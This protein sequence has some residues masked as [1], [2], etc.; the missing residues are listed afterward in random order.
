LASR[1]AERAKSRT[2]RGL[3]TVTCRPRWRAWPRPRA[4]RRRSP[5]APRAPRRPTARRSLRAVP[6]A[7]FLDEFRRARTDLEATYDQIES[8]VC[9]LR[10][11]PHSAG[12]P[13]RA[14]S[15]VGDV[16]TALTTRRSRGTLKLTAGH[17]S[18]MQM[19]L[20]VAATLSERFALRT[21]A[22][23]SRHRPRYRPSRPGEPRL[24]RRH[25]RLTRAA[26]VVGR[27]LRDTMGG[28]GNTPLLWSGSVRSGSGLGRPAE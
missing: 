25:E 10:N 12:V 5:R 11:V 3:T 20:T 1:P 22:R 16:A 6:P 7:R 26:F 8:A 14:S 19:S 15:R 24:T 2:W 13:G 27:W 9:V 23:P 21:M 4:R 18:L 17:P 28:E